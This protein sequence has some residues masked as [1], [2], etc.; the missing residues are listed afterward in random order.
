[1][2]DYFTS[3]IKENKTKQDKT[4]NKKIELLSC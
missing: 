4:P 2:N 1:M 3:I